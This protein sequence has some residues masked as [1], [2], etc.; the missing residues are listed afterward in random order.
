VKISFFEIQD[1]EIPILKKALQGNIL[2]FSK[3][4][5]TLANVKD[6]IDSD[7]VS[8]FIYSKIDK[9]IISKLPNLKFITTRSMG[10]DHIDLESCRKAKIKVATA[11][12][13]G[14][15]SVAEHTF[16]LILAIS[17]NIHKAYLRTVNKNYS[18]N[19]LKGFDLKGKTLGV[20]GVGRIGSH[21]VKIARG[22][23]MSVLAVDHSPNISLSKKLGFQYVSLDKLLKSSDIITLHVPYLKSNHHLINSSTLKKMKPGAII[24]NTSRGSV[25]DTKAVMKAL[26]SGKLSGLGIDV[27]EG[28]ELIKEEKELL[29]DL[30]QLDLKKMRQLAID[31]ELLNNEHVVFTPHIAFYSQEAV[32]RILEVTAENLIA[33]SKNKPINLIN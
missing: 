13:Y 14:D 26:E 20:I 11:P 16:G 31:H 21:V 25:L 23:E 9:E 2:Q 18:I 12:H 3:K 24:I 7:A 15:N 1:W 22:L 32:E 6:C 5:L 29:H 8:V 4:P 19:G 27:L 28:E 10:F 33:F 30:K 17:R